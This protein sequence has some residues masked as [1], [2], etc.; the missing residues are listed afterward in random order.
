MLIIPNLSIP[1]AINN[2]KISACALRIT[3]LSLLLL[4]KEKKGGAY[5]QMIKTQIGKRYEMTMLGS[6]QPRVL[7]SWTQSEAYD[8]ALPGLHDRSVIS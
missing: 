7:P 3:I 4:L 2:N 5:I 1:S 8:S 6:C